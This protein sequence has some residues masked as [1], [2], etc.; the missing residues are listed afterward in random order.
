MGRAFDIPVVIAW[1]PSLAPET[2]I[3]DP[4]EIHYLAEM[5]QDMVE[6]QR[7]LWDSARAY[8]NT[9]LYDWLGD[10][11]SG[12]I[13]PVYIDYCHMNSFGTAVVA[14]G[15]SPLVMSLGIEVSGDSEVTSDD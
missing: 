10:V 12:V 5:D 13:P 8:S 15:L 4:R 3:L 2:K 6:F 11:N 7:I 14:A 9:D 1:Q